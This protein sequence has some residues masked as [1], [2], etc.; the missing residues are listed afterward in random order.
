VQRESGS[1]S[2]VPCTH[3]C[4]ADTPN[5]PWSRTKGLQ[6]CKWRASAACAALESLR[7]YQTTTASHHPTKTRCSVDLTEHSVERARDVISMVQFQLCQIKQFL[8]SKNY[9][10]MLAISLPPSIHLPTCPAAASVSVLNVDPWP[11]GRCLAREKRDPVSFTT[12]TAG[13]TSRRR[14]IWPLFSPWP[15]PCT[16]L[17]RCLARLASGRRLSVFACYN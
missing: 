3:P 2:E 14:A 16:S 9:G 17:P 15:R 11:F 13:R 10:G 5:D 8:H 1:D 6:D 7:F 4:A 12:S